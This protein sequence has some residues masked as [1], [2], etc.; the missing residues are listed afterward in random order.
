MIKP[1]SFRYAVD[2][3][4]GVA[5]ITL[6]RPDT[7]NSLTFEVYAELRDTFR[8]SSHEAGCKAV[9]ITGAGARLLLGRQRARHHRR[10]CSR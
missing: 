8:R 9:V 4:A 10:R 3:G 6:D 1:K 5:T 2:P 7:L